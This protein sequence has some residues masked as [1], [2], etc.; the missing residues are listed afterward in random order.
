MSVAVLLYSC[1]L[2]VLCEANAQP[3]FDA[4]LRFADREWGYAML[5]NFTLLIALLIGLIAFVTR[6]LSVGVGLVSVGL[7]IPHVIN[8]Y[9]VLFRNEPFYP[10]DIE[11]AGETGNILGSIDLTFTPLLI[12]SII[13]LLVAII[14]AVLFDIFLGKKLRVRYWKQ[15]IAGAVLL[16]MLICGCVFLLDRDY[17]KSY[18]VAATTWNPADGYHQWSFLYSFIEYIHCSTVEKPDG[19]DE[20]TVTAIAEAAAEADTEQSELQPNIILVMSEA[21]ADI[22]NAKHLQFSEEL[23]PNL[24]ALSEQYLSGRAITGTWGGGTANSEFEVLTGY[25]TVDFSGRIMYMSHVNSKLDNYVSFLKGEGYNTVALHPYKRNFFGRDKAFE[26]MGFDSYYSLEHF[27][28]AE[29]ARWGNY[30]TDMAVTDRIIA[31]YEVN[32]K[33]DNPFFCH[34]VTMQNHTSYYPGEN[35]ASWAIETTTDGELTAEEVGRIDTYA[36][37]IRQSDMAL[38]A[39]IDYFEQVEEPTVV[40]F[41]GDHHPNLGSDAADLLYRAGYLPDL[42]SAESQMLYYSTPYLIWNNFEETPTHAEQDLSMYQLMPYMTEQYGLS[43]P[44]LFCF[45]DEL[46][47]VL[48]G[49]TGRFYLPAEGEA[50]LESSAEIKAKLKEYWYLIYDSLIGKQYAKEILYP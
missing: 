23:T 36:E 9:K 22:Q 18:G 41:Y 31:E 48:R 12:I 25:A 39:L 4:F 34:V 46:R 35:P 47:S 16:V 44:A 3:D 21:F 38:G 42:D 32:Q 37:G 6:K 28:D 40:V 26:L 45:M 20:Q 43:R 1:L 33:T 15:L 27:E 13:T 30:V 8:Y 24:D 10:W 50:T 5:R 14:G 11:L 49:H 2:A 17:Y 29:R 7:F 19:Y